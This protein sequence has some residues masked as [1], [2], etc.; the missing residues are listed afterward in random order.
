MGG[1]PVM[2]SI[3]RHCE[4][5]PI[6]STPWKTVEMT[7]PSM[8][9][10]AVHICHIIVK[11]PRMDLGAHS[12]AYTGVVL[13][14]APTAR[15]RTRRLLRKHFQFGDAA[16][17]NAVKHA[18]KHEKTIVPRRPYRWFNGAFSQQPINAA[19]A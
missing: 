18:K 6:K 12:A 7:N 14:L 16:C 8:M 4:L 10:K 15:P 17:Q 9:P 13:D 2:P 19:A 5:G 1:T 3:H 11:A